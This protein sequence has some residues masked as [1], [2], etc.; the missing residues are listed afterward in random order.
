MK[1]EKERGSKTKNKN[2]EKKYFCTQIGKEIF[3]ASFLKSQ[4]MNKIELIL[5]HK[6]KP[7]RMHN[8][9]Q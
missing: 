9:H 5:K 2:R 6:G 4:G 7:M 1:I 8:Y 3:S